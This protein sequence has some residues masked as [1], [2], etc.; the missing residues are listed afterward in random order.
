MKP[1]ILLDMDGV[2]ADFFNGVFNAAGIL[3]STDHITLEQPWPYN[4]AKWLENVSPDLAPLNRMSITHMCA[5][6]S[7]FWATLHIYP[8]ARNLVTFLM[9]NRFDVVVTTS[10]QDHRSH[11][12]K[13]DW[14]EH[15]FPELIHTAF[16][17]R[18]E[19][20]ANPNHLLIDDHEENCRK[21]R[22][23]GGHTILYPQPWNSAHM[24][25]KVRQIHVQQLLSCYA[26]G[27]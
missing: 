24:L 15:W 11:V 9:D 21:F 12:Q 17:D 13:L 6:D 1:I 20:M 16:I 10:P 23:R 26:N 2:L 7:R 8:D 3:Q 14:L 27:I 25:T 18:K 22:A 4:V 5:A 19:L